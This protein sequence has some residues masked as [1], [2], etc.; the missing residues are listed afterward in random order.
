M[1]NESS[2]KAIS[3][4]RS[5]NTGVRSTQADINPD[6]VLEKGRRAAEGK[7]PNS[8][9]SVAPSSVEDDVPGT[10]DPS[11]TDLPTANRPT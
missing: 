1:T 10:S 8:A 7:A 2:D 11:V 9:G 6:E 5:E 3:E 4:E